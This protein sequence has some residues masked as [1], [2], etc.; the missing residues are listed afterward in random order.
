MLPTR[1]KTRLLQFGVHQLGA[2]RQRS[3]TP[4]CD[5]EASRLNAGQACTSRH[6]E[7]GAN[8]LCVSFP[9]PEESARLVGERKEVSGPEGARRAACGA[10]HIDTDKFLRISDALRSRVSM[11]RG[12]GTSSASSSAASIGD[13]MTESIL[14]PALD[15]DQASFADSE[16]SSFYQPT[17]ELRCRLLSGAVLCSEV[18]VASTV[19]SGMA[20]IRSEH[21]YLQGFELEQCR[22]SHAGSPVAYWGPLE[23][24][25][26]PQGIEL[27][28]AIVQAAGV[29]IGGRLRA[30]TGMMDCLWESVITSLREMQVELG[31]PVAGLNLP[32]VPADP[33]L[34]RMLIADI[35]R[36]RELQL[37]HGWDGMD[38]SGFEQVNWQDYLD[39]VARGGPGEAPEIQAIANELRIIIFVTFNTG[40]RVLFFRGAG[41][42]NNFIVVRF[43]PSAW[44]RF[45]GHYDAVIVLQ[46]SG[47]DPLFPDAMPYSRDAALRVGLVI[48][49]LGDRAGLPEGGQHI[50][51]EA[52]YLTN[53]GR[54]HGGWI[55]VTGEGLLHLLRSQGLLPPYRVVE[56]AVDSW[57]DV[58]GTDYYSPIHPHIFYQHLVLVAAPTLSGA[59]A[60]G[61]AGSQGEASGSEQGDDAGLLGPSAPDKV[62]IPSGLPHGCWIEVDVDEFDSTVTPRGRQ[63][64]SNKSCRARPVWARGMPPMAKSSIWSTWTPA[65]TTCRDSISLQL[66]GE[67]RPSS[68]G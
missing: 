21:Q 58:D 25:S 4:L 59:D 30:A 47:P 8:G 68:Y 33:G 18:P 19:G 11:L 39:D 3:G 51:P 13:P 41:A 67:H 53:P 65:K 48:R 50:N 38:P 35:M 20:M 32:S 60:A 44:G 6:C 34:F 61:A 26:T 29:P 45:E 55:Q 64:S 57:R 12:A 17:V 43:N 16:R 36:R 66:Q 46:D 42:G 49:G 7:A 62:L 15:E 1:A 40:S 56:D 5:D 9:S 2:E 63:A 23:A 52:M 24:F 14:A 10:A 37:A 28:L 31:E 54:A 27:D 22:L